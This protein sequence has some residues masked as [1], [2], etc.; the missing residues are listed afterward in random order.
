MERDE[1]SAPISYKSPK[2][3]A[4]RK[5]CSRMYYGLLTALFFSILVLSLTSL[6]IFANKNDDIKG[7]VKGDAQC[8]L[9]VDEDELKSNK[10]SDGSSCAFALWGSGIVGLGAAIFMLSY[11]IRAVLGA[12]L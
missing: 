1:K 6:G 4:C 5:T 10:L 11:V 3:G 9:Y 8:I 12:R 7:G 2:P